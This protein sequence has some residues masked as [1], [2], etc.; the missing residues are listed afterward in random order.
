MMEWELLLLKLTKK[1]KSTNIKRY[2]AENLYASEYGKQQ[3]RKTVLKRYGVPCA[4]KA[5]SVKQKI[6]T[7]WTFDEMTTFLNNLKCME[8]TT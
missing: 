5:D 6:V 1:I 8:G 4:S 7:L 3:I 2:G